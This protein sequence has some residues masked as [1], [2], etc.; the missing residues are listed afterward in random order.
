M[1][2]YTAYH[3]QAQSPWSYAKHNNVGSDAHSD[4]KDR[5]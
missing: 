3:S 5:S 1:G 2:R 4:A